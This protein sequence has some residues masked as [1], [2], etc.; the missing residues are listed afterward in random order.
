MRAKIRFF[1]GLAEAAGTRET[2]VE[3]GE[4]LSAAEAFRLLCERFPNLSDHGGSLMYAVNAEYVSSDHPLRGGD[5][6]ALIPPV[7][8]GGRAV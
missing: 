1:A 5:E 7:S 6:L 3:L 4:G 8:G 2:E